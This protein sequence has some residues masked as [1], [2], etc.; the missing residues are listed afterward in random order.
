VEGL[1]LEMGVLT[2]EEDLVTV[3]VDALLAT[4]FTVT[5]TL[6]APIGAVPGTVTAM[7]D[8][9]QVVVD[10]TAPPK[11]TVPL[12]PNVVPEIVTAVPDGPV[13][14]DRLLICGAT[15]KVQLLE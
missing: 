1:R 4:L 5:T 7:L 15:V 8:D 11:V 10:A 2:E 12:D 13:V 6:S 14:T 3:N 9:V